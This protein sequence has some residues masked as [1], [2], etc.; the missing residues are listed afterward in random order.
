MKLEKSALG[1]DI[2][3]ASSRDSPVYAVALVKNDEVVFTDERVEA[4]YLLRYI[5]KFKPD[6]LATDN[7]F[8]LARNE[9]EIRKLAFLL[10]DKTCLVQVTGNPS[11]P[12]SSLIDIAR[13][14]GFEV[15]TKLSPVETAIIAAKLALKEEGYK[16]KLKENE[17]FII[18]TK[19]IE[20]SA[21]G[22]SMSRYKR[23]IFSNISHAISIIKGILN[24][25]HLPY[26]F[27]PSKHPNEG[28]VFIVQAQRDIVKKYIKPYEGYGIRIRIAPVVR[29]RIIN[30]EEIENSLRLLLVGYDP[31]ITVGIAAIDLKGNLILLESNKYTGLDEIREKLA[32]HGRPIIISTDKPSVPVMV[33]KLASSFGAEIFSPKGEMRIDEKKEIVKKYL[34]EKELFNI[35]LDSHKRDALAAVINAFKKYQPLYNEIEEEIKKA[36]LERISAQEVFEKVIKSKKNVKE[37]IEEIEKS[38]TSKEIKIKEIRHEVYDKEEIE[39]NKRK[40]EEMKSLIK[41]LQ[42]IITEKE[43]VITSLKKK[44]EMLQKEERARIRT[45]REVVLLN[46]RIEILI[47]E[48]NKL[49][50]EMEKYRKIFKAINDSLA[51]VIEKKSEL[52]VEEDPT[53]L[54]DKQREVRIFRELPKFE[55][56][57]LNLLLK[58]RTKAI[59]YKDKAEE[60][61]LRSLERIGIPV[62]KLEEI[63]HMDLGNIVIVNKSEL[64]KKI[65]EKK[66]KLIEFD[67]EERKKLIKLF[68]DYRKLKI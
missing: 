60:S 30:K 8:E 15:G 55:E 1:V 9:N 6:F 41:L 4:K 63:P 67:D 33:S 2:T 17:T 54:E 29:N 27:F 43:N 66:S 59:L 47:E 56:K 64:C 48:N 61:T 39:K 3:P 13:A 40:L 57:T 35:K 14:R 45:N 53:A 31:G 46:Q 49:R 50:E 58:N 10:P 23:K 24:N 62:I 38:I 51:E 18:V 36:N 34:E 7:V 25:N 68:E 32:R 20:P 19:A 37:T 42:N 65:E 12:S 16:I 28:G 21:G 22:M 26:D 11:S 44:I 5:K 52:L